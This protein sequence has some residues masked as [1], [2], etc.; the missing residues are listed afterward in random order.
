MNKVNE[1]TKILQFLAIIF[2]ISTIILIGYIIY[3]KVTSNGPVDNPDVD[4]GEVDDDK[5]DEEDNSNIKEEPVIKEISL[6]DK[7]VQELLKRQT[8][9]VSSIYETDGF[10]KDHIPNYLILRT[11]FV[12]ASFDDSAQQV[13]KEDGQW[14]L[15]VSAKNLEKYIKKIFGNVSYKHQTFD[16]EHFTSHDTLTNPITYYNGVYSSNMEF[17][18]GYHLL[19]YIDEQPYKAELINDGEKIYVYVKTVFVSETYNEE[20]E[21]SI[22]NAYNDYNFDTNKYLNKVFSIVKKND[23]FPEAEFNK[24]FDKNYD[25]I[26]SYIYTFEKQADGN[27][28][29]SGFNKVK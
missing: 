19:N 2:A 3:D 15:E 24:Q 23:T 11:A 17:G 22:I 20:T 4:N 21:K 27:Y 10:T 1:K 16:L 9:I 8:R 5:S 29:L 26:N 6:N 14:V 13:E 18:G 7:T 28:Y 12:Y 25:K